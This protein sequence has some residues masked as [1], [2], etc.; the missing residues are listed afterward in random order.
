MVVAIPV[1]EAVFAFTS[2]L[3]FKEYGALVAPDMGKMLR[4][5][6]ASTRLQP[7]DQTYFAEYPN[8][9]HL[10]LLASEETPDTTMVAP[11]VQR[12]AESGPR[13]DF[14]IV[15]DVTDLS[16]LN[17]ILDDELDLDEDLAGLELPVLFIFDEEWNQVGQWGPRPQTAEE[18]LDGWLAANP[19]YENLLNEDVDDSDELDRLFDELTHLMGFWY[20]TDL[21]DACVA[22][23][24][25]VLDNARLAAGV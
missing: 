17:D 16:L 11:I 12:I 2:G 24:R 14:R 8:W 15:P 13:F 3:S 20:N 4:Q 18:R 6:L 5:R 23:I 19:A 7:D 21:T 9:V 25:Q 22:E 1:Q 10:I